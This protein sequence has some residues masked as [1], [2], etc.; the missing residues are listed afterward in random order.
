MTASRSRS[1]C[2]NR[3]GTGLPRTR[4][5]RAFGARVL[6]GRRSL[7]TVDVR[8][9]SNAEACIRPATV[10]VRLSSKYCGIDG[11]HVRLLA[12]C[13]RDVFEVA[14][15]TFSYFA[16]K[17]RPSVRR[18]AA[19]FERPL[20]EDQV[21]GR[22]VQHGPAAIADGARS[23]SARSDSSARLHPA[24]VLRCAPALAAR[25]PSPAPH[26]RPREAPSRIASRALRARRARTSTGITPRARGSRAARRARV[27]DGRGDRGHRRERRANASAIAAHRPQRAFSSDPCSDSHPS[28]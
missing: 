26:A 20:P 24:A 23:A 4:H 18:S 25:A 16:G 6:K 19:D 5:V 7:S 2:R 22:V 12:A 9:G 14:L 10:C 15:D 21:H 1:G 27:R 17:A 13:L 28:A 8:A 3:A 11:E